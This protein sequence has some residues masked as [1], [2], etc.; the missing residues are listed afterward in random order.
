[1]A[2]Y[3]NSYKSARINSKNCK[4]CPEPATVTDNNN[5]NISDNTLYKTKVEKCSYMLKNNLCG[6][7]NPFINDLDLC[8]E[9]TNYM[10]YNYLQNI[11]SDPPKINAFGR[12]SNTTGGSGMPPRNKF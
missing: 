6:K 10:T 3:G 11:K 9:K 4:S 1:M 12:L 5:N 8:K 7:K 2:S